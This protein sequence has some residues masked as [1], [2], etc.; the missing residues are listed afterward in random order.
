VLAD[1]GY[2]ISSVFDLPQAKHLAQ[3]LG[4]TWRQVLNAAFTAPDD[5][6]R[7]LRQVAADK[8]RVG[9][10]LPVLYQSL[11]QAARRI[12]STTL[13]RT[14]YQRAREQ[15]IAA[16]RRAGAGAAAEQSMPSLA[17]VDIALRREGLSWDQALGNA[18]LQRARKARAALSAAEAVGAFVEDLEALPRNLS[19][20]RRWAV[21]RQAATVG[22]TSAVFD[23]AVADLAAERA[24]GGLPELPIAQPQA[25]QEPG[26]LDASVLPP[27][28]AAAG[29]WDRQRLI[30]GMAKAT[31]LLADGEVLDQRALKRLAR[32]NPGQGI[33][34]YNQVDRCRKRDHPAET[35]AEW[36][37]EAQ[38][39]ARQPYPI[40]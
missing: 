34:S 15:M 29:S 16:A 9:L 33:P 27:R 26:Q 14:D 25:E 7:H 19:Q 23:Q 8:S 12:N 35:W 4:L 10:T 18:G 11:R 37:R 13:D 17:Q 2:S 24:S 22:I 6:L 32:D 30:L 5:T 39:V 38:A 21:A 3:Q 1:R 31:R 40:P 36:V 20:L 28:I